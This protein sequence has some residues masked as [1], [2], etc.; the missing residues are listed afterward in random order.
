MEVVLPL[1]IILMPVAFIFE[2]LI[3]LPSIFIVWPFAKKYYWHCGRNLWTWYTYIGQAVINIWV[4][5]ISIGTVIFLFI[6]IGFIGLYKI[7]K[8]INA[9]RNQRI[10]EKLIEI[11]E[12]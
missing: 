12:D 1:T 8:Q 6:P 4:I 5:V 10:K 2:V 7:N 11:I 9:G 3:V